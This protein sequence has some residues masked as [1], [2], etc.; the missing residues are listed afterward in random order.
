MLERKKVLKPVLY[1]QVGINKTKLLKLN[2]E[3]STL[4][5]DRHWKHLKKCKQVIENRQ[6]QKEL[7]KQTLLVV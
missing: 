7:D 1:Y 3:K 6:K 2:P 4:F 5:Q